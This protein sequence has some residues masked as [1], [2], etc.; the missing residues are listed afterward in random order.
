MTGAL[1]FRADSLPLDAWK[2]DAVATPDSLGLEDGS[3]WVDVAL[4]GGSGRAGVGFSGKADR[5]GWSGRGGTAMEQRE[6]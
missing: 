4:E 3:Y 2:E 1:L 6:L 5:P